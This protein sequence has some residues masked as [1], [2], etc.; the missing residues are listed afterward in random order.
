VEKLPIAAAAV[1]PD[2]E[3]VRPAATQSYGNRR[4]ANLQGVRAMAAVTS[5]A[6]LDEAR[7]AELREKFFQLLDVDRD[8]EEFERLYQEVDAALEELVAEEPA[9]RL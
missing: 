4:Q 6:R 1:Q 2:S 7:M 8:S 5:L 3:K 9:V